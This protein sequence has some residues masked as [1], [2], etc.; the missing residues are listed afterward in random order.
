MFDEG[1][2]ERFVVAIELIQIELVLLPWMN[3]KYVVC[4]CAN[5]D[6]YM[7]LNDTL[8]LVVFHIEG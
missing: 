4:I 8:V 1:N 3:C 6:V 2:V 7:D 5:T